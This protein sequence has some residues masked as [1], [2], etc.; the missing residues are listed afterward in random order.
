MSTQPTPTPPDLSAVSLHDLI[1][2]L[3]RRERAGDCLAL[4]ITPGDFSEYWESD[5]SG[6]THPGS[7][8][9]DAGEMHACKKAFERWQDCGGFSE[10]METCRDAWNA[11][12]DK[13]GSK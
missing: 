11:A 2:E 9:P 13:G 1:M 10:I 7:R 4:V 8:V 3:F 12:S 5:E 6:A